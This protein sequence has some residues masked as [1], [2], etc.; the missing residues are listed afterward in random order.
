MPGIKSSS[1]THSHFRKPVCFLPSLAEIVINPDVFIHFLEEFLHGLWWLPCKILGCRSWPK[2]LDHGL[3]N[4]FIGH[5]R[6][7]GSQTQEL[8]DVC[9]QVLMVLH[10]LEQGLSGDWLR[11]KALKAGD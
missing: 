3:N 8:S 7:L 6:R 4:N 10:E 5:Y 2:P 9:L 1:E 11:L